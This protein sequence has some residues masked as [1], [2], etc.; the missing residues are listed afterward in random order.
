VQS[1][2]GGCT[3]PRQPRLLEHSEPS[4]FF[5]AAL[6]RLGDG[7][8]FRVH[9]RSGFQYLRIRQ[10]KLSLEADAEMEI[11]FGIPGHLSVL[12]M[13]TLTAFALIS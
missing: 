9:A 6:A 7:Y 4:N 8:L 1:I 11:S 13:R 3:K 5:H 12:V 10:G 2:R